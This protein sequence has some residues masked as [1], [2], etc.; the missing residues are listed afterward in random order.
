MSKKIALVSACLLGLPTRYDGKELTCKKVLELSKEYL[1]IPICPEQLGGLPTPRKPSEIRESRVVDCDGVDV[2]EH[3]NRGA[4]AVLKIA[5]RLMPD[6]II[7]KERSPSC[8]VTSIADGTFTGK[9]RTGQGIAAQLL[10][11]HFKIVSEE[12]LPLTDTE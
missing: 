6:I 11:K 9:K 7:L 12:Q 4:E 3:F 5:Q 10:Q 8:G 2:T 1:L